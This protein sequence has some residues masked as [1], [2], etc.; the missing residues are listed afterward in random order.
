MATP[1]RVSPRPPI[2]KADPSTLDDDLRRMFA[3][4]GEKAYHDHELF[5]TM[6]RRPGVLRATMG[7]VR[8]IYGD[9][10]IDRRLTEMVRIRTAWNNRCRH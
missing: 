10:L 6:A 8:Y 9:S 7:F 5:L 3:G 2:G 1:D 4:W